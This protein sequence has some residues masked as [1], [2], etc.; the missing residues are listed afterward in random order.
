M[1]SATGTNNDA[2][3]AQ[4]VRWDVA[5]PVRNSFGGQDLAGRLGMELVVVEDRRDAHTVNNHRADGV[6]Q[7]HRERLVRLALAIAF[8]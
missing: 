3:G 4:T 6:A 8:D 2:P 1:R 5:R 7:L